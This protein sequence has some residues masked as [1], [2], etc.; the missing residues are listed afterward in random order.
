MIFDC[1]DFT[2]IKYC[3]GYAGYSRKIAYAIERSPVK[4]T[5]QSFNITGRLSMAVLLIDRLLCLSGP[6]Y[7]S[8][9]LSE[10]FNKPGAWEPGGVIS[11]KQR[12]LH[13]AARIFS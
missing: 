11:L 7:D 5:K 4:A 12:Q 8:F 10:F 1:V 13:V 6:R 2:V 3:W 9:L